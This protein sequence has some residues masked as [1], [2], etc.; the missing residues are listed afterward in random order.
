MARIKIES[1]SEDQTEISDDMLDDVIGGSIAPSNAL[2]TFGSLP[3]SISRP[4]LGGGRMNQ[5][6]QGTS[7]FTISFAAASSFSDRRLKTGI[8]AL[9][10]TKSG[11]ATYSY[12]YIWD[13]APR[14][15]VM[16]DEAPRHAVTQTASGYSRVDYAKIGL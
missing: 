14:I 3:A 5:V 4:A 8:K 1:L 9:G 12:R 2:F 15:G 11:M 7:G 6:S 10:H 13:K 16:A